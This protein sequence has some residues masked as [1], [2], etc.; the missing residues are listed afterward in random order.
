MKK[1]LLIVIVTVVFGG[2][3]TTNATRTAIV[4]YRQV[5]QSQ[6]DLIDNT[7]RIANEQLYLNLS[8][9]V[10][11]NLNDPDKIFAALKS[12]WKARQ[13]LEELRVQYSYQ[14]TK[15]NIT[16]GQYLYDQQ[17]WAN[18]LFEDILTDASRASSAAATA[19]KAAGVN[20]VTDLIPIE[21]KGA[22]D[23][24]LRKQLGIPPAPATTQSSPAGQ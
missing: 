8:Q 22:L 19:D 6:Q 7:L 1:L 14:R 21:L 11:A 24:E 15:S 17:G 16:V 4:S 13:T 20:S 10:R 23:A 9:Y 18:V 3:C 5:Q 12:A 2:G